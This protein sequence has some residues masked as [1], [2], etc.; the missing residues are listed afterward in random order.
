MSA[1]HQ[2]RARPRDERVHVE[3]DCAAR[4][5][6]ASA[7]NC[8]CPHSA[9]GVA[10]SSG[11]R[12]GASAS[13]STPRIV[14][15]QAGVRRRRRRRPTGPAPRQQPRSTRSAGR[16]RRAA[17]RPAD[18]PMGRAAGDCLGRERE[19]PA[20]A[21]LARSIETTTATPSATPRTARP[22]CQGW[23]ARWRRRDAGEL[24]RH[25]PL[26]GHLA[27]TVRLLDEPSALDAKTRSA[28][29]TTS[30]LCVTIS[31]FLPAR[32]RACRAGP[33]RRPPSRRRGCRSARRP[34][35][36]AGRGPAR[37]RLR[38]AAARRRRAGRGGARR[39]PSPTCSSS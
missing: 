39:S 17:R 19:R 4:L 35:R 22:T 32:G 34:A 38:R 2:R 18:D 3:S 30:G 11:T 31:R 1:A 12:N 33:A 10:P 7:R 37:G 28:T 8:P 5:G 36:A 16:R 14:Q 20:R 25:P 26:P 13:G 15:R 29:P 6:P 23:R 24:S 27:V 21:L 9:V